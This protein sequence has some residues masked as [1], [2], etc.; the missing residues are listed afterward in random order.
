MVKL[1][2]LLSLC[3]VTLTTSWSQIPTELTDTVRVSYWDGDLGPNYGVEYHYYKT[4]SQ[5]VFLDFEDLELHDYTWDSSNG[6]LDDLTWD[7]YFEYTYSTA[8]EGTFVFTDNEVTGDTGTFAIYDASWDL[9]HNGT[10]DGA[11]IEAGLLPNYSH[12]QLGLAVSGSSS[13]WLSNEGASSSDLSLEFSAQQIDVIASGN[14]SWGI[15]NALWVT[16]SGEIHS[17]SWNNDWTVDV[18][19]LNSVTVTDGGTYTDEDGDIEAINQAVMWLNLRTTAATVDD[20]PDF[21]EIALQDHNGV[22]RI[23]V[24]SDLAASDYAV[25]YSPVEEVHIRLSYNSTAAELTSAYSYDGNQYTDLRTSSVAALP[26]YINGDPLAVALGAESDNVQINAGENTFKELVV[27]SASPPASLAG[28]QIEYQP[29]G[30]ETSSVPWQE[31]YGSDGYA[32][33]GFSGSV[34]ERIPY[35]YAQGVVTYTI[36]DEEI[37]L[38][39]ETATS[40]T[41]EYVELDGADLFVDEVG[42]FSI[43]VAPT[44]EVKTDDW[45]R[46]ET[47]DSPLSTDYWNIARRTVDKVDYNAGELSFI[48][49]NGGEP[50]EEDYPEIEIEYGRT[51]PLDEN[52]QVVLDDLYASSVSDFRIGFDLSL[53]DSDT[54]VG[55]YFNYGDYGFGGRQVN[56]DVERRGDT[57]VYRAGAFVRANQDARL[58]GGVN[59]RVRHNAASRDLLF[60]YQPDGA[61][62][63]TELARLNLGD[64]TFAGT[65]QYGD[66]VAPISGEVLSASERFAMDVEVEA[67]QATQL[68][69]LEIAGIEI[70]SYTPPVWELYDDFS[71]SALDAE[72]W[73]TWYMPGGLEPT[74]NTGELSLG[75]APGNLGAKDIAIVELQAAFNDGTDNNGVTFTDPSIIGVE[76]E[77]RLPADVAME[78]GVYIG[79]VSF[80]VP[81]V[82]FAG[83]ELANRPTGPKLD[84]EIDEIDKGSQPAILGQTYRLRMTHID[85]Q[86]QIFIDGSLVLDDSAPGE[87]LGFIIGAFNDAGQAMTA[88]VDNVRVLRDTTPEP[89]LP[90]PVIES[91]GN[92]DLLEDGSG[93]YAGSAE[94][95]LVYQGTQ[96]SSGTYAG[97]TALG[98]DLVNGTYRVVRSNGSQYYAA[99]FAL[100]G[101]NSSTWAVVANVPAEEVNLQQDLNSDGYVGIA[102]PASLA[103][104]AYQFSLGGGYTWTVP[105]ELVFGSTTYDEGFAGS[106]LDADQPY[107]YANGVVTTDGGDELRLTFQT[108]TSGSFESWELDEVGYYLDEVGTFNLVTASLVLKNDWQHSET[109]DSA[110]ST[111]YWNSGLRGIDSLEYNDGELNFVIG[112]GGYAVANQGELEVK[113]GRTLPMDENWQVVLDDIFVSDSVELFEIKLEVELPGTDFECGL[114]FGTDSSADYGNETGAA[115]VGVG[116]EYYGLEKDAF[117]DNS[118]DARI[119]NSLNLRVVHL[120][121]SRELVFE[122]QP[123]GASGWTE[124]ARLNLANGGFTGSNARDGGFSGELVNATQRMAFGVQVEAGQ[125]I[126]I[127]DLT[128]GGIEIGSYTPPQEARWE[129]AGWV[130]YAWPYAY[131]F[132]EGRWHFFNQSDKQWRV[133]LTDSQWATLDAAT[134]WNY[135][136][137]PYSYSSDQGAWHWYNSNIQW[138]VDLASGEWEL[139]GGSD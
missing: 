101:S 21:L 120:A 34:I 106:L 121:I 123:E 30:G 11:Q 27:V 8:S 82:I 3:L 85:G 76:A 65:N 102:P 128:I 31:L 67:G 61:S 23:K 115:H 39:F 89:P 4:N 55:C 96:F 75:I 118:N 19:M 131:D 18:V 117:V 51:L 137:W 72:K 35:T 127:G 32:Q 110:L 13:F 138:V 53:L 92:T 41:Y 2:I 132:T 26:S 126:E 14:S 81:E 36:F 94:T 56:A 17:L 7:E 60:E 40:G 47:M 93:Y 16:N 83:I 68:G 66:G 111:N 87:F 122:Y 64:G 38:S 15:V 114:K 139:F 124:L 108:A 113:Y 135:Y 134:G 45:Q 136:A 9:D 62:G 107:T 5:L 77:L 79:S 74:V 119:G 73:E 71:G 10:P 49:A 105:L 70:G 125:A 43:V 57:Y 99:N 37:R 88:Y 24:D 44:L 133:N 95:P 80:S 46:S 130:Y 33:F 112:D 42:T 104:K 109:M 59:L 6:R 97:F 100:N 129:P 22:K 48:F 69:D 58:Q 98:V 28:K 20:D 90:V 116:I 103:G 54:E 52:W 78:S 12:L 84:I 63:W 25:A 29:S 50:G 91:Y 1:H 86:I